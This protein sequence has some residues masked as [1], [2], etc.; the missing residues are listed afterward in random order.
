MIRRHFSWPTGRWW[1]ICLL[2]LCACLSLLACSDSPTGSDASNLPPQAPVYGY[3]V[4]RAYPH[5]REAFTQGLAFDDQGALYES[6]GQRG[7]SS[8][9]RVE[10]SS[11]AVLPRHDLPAAL[12]GE[13]VAVFGDRIFQ[14]TWQA[15][16]A[17]V[18]DKASFDLLREFTYRTEGWGLTHDGRRL[19][20]SDGTA[21]LYFLRP[22]TF[23][24]T[25]RLTVR[26]HRGPVIRLNELEYVRGEIFANVWQTDRIARIDPRTGHVTG[27]IDLT[28]LLPPGDPRRPVD[29]L[30]GIAYDP[31]TDRLFVTGKWWP[32]LFEITL[33]R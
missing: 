27:W 13:G 20:M 12:F 10:L 18:Y 11:G 26:D 2:T 7:E 29:V 24:E 19:I 30:N 33:T 8:L 23:A 21:T 1:L 31:R 17:L 6:T 5:D 15:G 16:R 32:K 28:G 9:R 22:D 25:A 14:L 4:V 3:T